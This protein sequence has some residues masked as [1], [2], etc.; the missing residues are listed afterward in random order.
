MI[1][2]SSGRLVARLEGLEGGPSATGT[3]SLTWSG[4]DGQGRLVPAGTYW[5]V[6]RGRE[7]SATRSILILR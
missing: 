1:V 4:R 3:H 5:A 6:A 2:D 7:G